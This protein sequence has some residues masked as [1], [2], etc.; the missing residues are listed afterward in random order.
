MTTWSVLLGLHTR[1]VSLV[2]E[3]SC[4]PAGKTS[5]IA[6]LVGLLVFCVIWLLPILLTGIGVAVAAWQAPNW[7]H[8][9]I[10][11]AVRPI[12]L[13]RDLVPG[14]PLHGCTGGLVADR[15]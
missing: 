5:S 6:T 4:S 10:V 2:N 3:T 9:G 14:P 13:L 15:S 1:T 12:E 7:I 8:Q 11:D